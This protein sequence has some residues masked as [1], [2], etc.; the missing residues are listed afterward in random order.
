MA[1][2]TLPVLESLCTAVRAHEHS[3]VVLDDISAWAHA[4]GR[5]LSVLQ[6][7]GAA[8]V[9]TMQQDVIVPRAP[10]RGSSAVSRREQL[11]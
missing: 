10:G 7:N 11:T 9:A 4:W 5:W 8:L 3:L 2:R 6:H 1:G